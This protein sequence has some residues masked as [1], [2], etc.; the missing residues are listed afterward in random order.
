[1][2]FKLLCAGSRGAVGRSSLVTG[3]SGE[4]GV[5]EAV[6]RASRTLLLLG[7]IRMGCNPSGDPRIEGRS[8]LGTVEFLNG[9]WDSRKT[10]SRE[11]Y[12]RPEEM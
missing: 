12:R 4:S 1:M 9:N 7:C 6:D 11:I 3:S 2:E 8:E 10:T 5:S